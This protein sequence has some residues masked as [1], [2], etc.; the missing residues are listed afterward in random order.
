MSDYTL[1]NDVSQLIA[2]SCVG[3]MIPVLALAVSALLMR[4]L[5]AFSWDSLFR[6]RRDD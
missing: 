1:T 6:Y 2:I 4:T 5:R 3:S